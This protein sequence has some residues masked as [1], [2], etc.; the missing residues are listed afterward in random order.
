MLW[1][2]KGVIKLCPFYGRRIASDSG[3]GTEGGLVDVQPSLPA[4]FL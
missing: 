2:N 1:T 3:S 4:V